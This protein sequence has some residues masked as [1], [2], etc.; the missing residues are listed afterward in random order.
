MTPLSE[1]N[2]SAEQVRDVQVV[3]LAGGKGT[4]LAEETTMRPKPMVAIG[5]R[6][7]LWHIMNIYAS[8]GHERFLVACGY[9]GDM[10]KE[11]FHQYAVRHG[12]FRIRLGTGEVEMVKPNRLDW[13]VGVV[14]TG[15]D[16]MTGG[17][18]TPPASAP[19]SESIVHGHL[20]RR[21]GRH[22]HRPLLGSTTR[23]ASWRP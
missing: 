11:Y 14:D 2:E 7:I 10:I 5:N 16:T 21:R 18:V 17:R 22:R 3:I 19:G 23:T 12:D 6:P 1:S 8:H 15:L 13:D 9:K 4:R 20:W